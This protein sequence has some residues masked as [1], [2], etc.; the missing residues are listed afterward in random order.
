MWTAAFADAP[1]PSGSMPEHQFEAGDTSRWLWII[2][3]AE[4]D[5]WAAALRCGSQASWQKMATPDHRHFFVLAG[6]VCYVIDAE[7]QRLAASVEERLFADLIAIPGTHL[8][9]V[10]DHVRVAIVGLDGMVW[11]TPRIAWDGVRLIDA[12]EM[13]IVG[14]AEGGHGIAEDE[15]SFEIDLRTRAV[16]GGHRHWFANTDHS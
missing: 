7:S 3:S 12:T 5:E 1:P 9:A 8:A 11:M 13:R 15:C 14:I 6:G 16:T 2:F 10:A 4:G